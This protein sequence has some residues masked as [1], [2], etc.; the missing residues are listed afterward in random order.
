MITP[1]KVWFVAPRTNGS[2][3]GGMLEGGHFE[4][5][6]EDEEINWVVGEGYR[7]RFCGE[8]AC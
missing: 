1:M 8:S 7:E 6:D 4:K 2:R 3:S 5:V